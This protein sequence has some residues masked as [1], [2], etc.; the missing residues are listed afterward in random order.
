[1]G[2]SSPIFL[3]MRLLK[4]RDNSLNILAILMNLTFLPLLVDL[5]EFEKS[6]NRILNESL[7]ALWY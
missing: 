1:M 6:G 3:T 2:I 5:D 7:T 4:R